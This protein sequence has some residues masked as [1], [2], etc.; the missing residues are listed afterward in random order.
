[1]AVESTTLT[2][3]GDSAGWE[4]WWGLAYSNSSDAELQFSDDGGSTWFA[5]LDK[6]AAAATWTAA[7]YKFVFMPHGAL[8][9]A[10]NSD[11]T[12]WPMAASNVPKAS[13]V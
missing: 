10:V 4:N 3:D 9:K 6:D 13:K 1:M 11:V 5:A 2:G 7:G 12:V 8:I